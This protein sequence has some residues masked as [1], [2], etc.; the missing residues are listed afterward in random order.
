MDNLHK[1]T[2][3]EQDFNLWTETMLQQIRERNFDA[4]D[5]E[6][7]L[8]EIEGLNRSDKRDLERRLTVLLEHILKLNYWESEREYNARGWEVTIFE[9]LDEIQML[10][11]DSP[12]LKRYLSEIFPGCYSKAKRD[13]IRKTGLPAH[14]FPDIS[15]FSFEQILENYLTD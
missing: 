7:L 9:Q 1:S 10:L 14:T 12:S 11:R 8:E 4:V 6:N 2:L 3:Y 15:P 5:W 13:A